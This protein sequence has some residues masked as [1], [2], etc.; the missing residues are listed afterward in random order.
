MVMATLN[1]AEGRV[2]NGVCQMQKP[3]TKECQD[4]KQVPPTVTE[5]HAE[6]RVELI[7]DLENRVKWSRR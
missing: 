1:P 5:F 2:R 6:R 3:G 7:S 4:E